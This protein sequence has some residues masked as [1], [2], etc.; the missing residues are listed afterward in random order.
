MLGEELKSRREK[1][2]LTLAQISEVTRIGTRFLRAIETD[3]FSILPEGIYTRS[4]IRAYAKHVHMDE[5]QAM[6]LYQEQTGTPETPADPVAPIVD[7]KPFTFKEPVSGFWP[8][9]VVAAALALVLSTGA[10]ALFH[11]MQKSAEPPVTSA[12]SAAPTSS[13]PPAP[14]APQ[15][16][17]HAVSDD[18]TLQVTLQASDDCWIGYTADGGKRTQKKL[19]EG[20]VEQI[21]ANESV[22][23]TIGNTRV[24]SMQINGREAH[25]PA[26]TGVVLKKLTITPET[27]QTL[28]N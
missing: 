27:A 23:L 7:E 11:Y 1:L 21:Q 19:K 24:V 26:D 13:E 8:A 18:G 2:G 4:F 17:V 12:S 6:R 3:D 20:D 28:V 25:F 9:A 10:W 14:T 16:P 22:D 15:P 5:E